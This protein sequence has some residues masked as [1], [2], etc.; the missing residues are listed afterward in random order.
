MVLL[1]K[2]SPKKIL[3]KKKKK[4]NEYLVS[5]FYNIRFLGACDEFP[6]GVARMKTK[7]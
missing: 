4:T 7:V 1:W 2:N 5:D 3:K 6:K